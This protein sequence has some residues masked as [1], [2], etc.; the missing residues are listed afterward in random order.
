MTSPLREVTTLFL[1]L[2]L[3][4]FGGPAAH[5]ALMHE[6]VV[7]RRRWVDDA[8]FLD[9]VGLA[10]LVPGP[11]STELAIHLGRERAGWRGFAAA[12][13]AFIAPAMLMVLG[14]A[15]LY[16][17]YGALPQ[18]ASLLE[19]VKAVMIA[20][21]AQALWT[22]VPKAV[23]G[24][25]TGVLGAAALALALAGVHEIALLFGAGLLA[26]GIRM[27]RGGP[28]PVAIAVPVAALRDSTPGAVTAAAAAATAAIAVPFSLPLL[29][30]SFLKIGAVM[31]G[32][33]YVLL[34]FLRA[35]F[36]TRFGWLT[37]QQVLDAVAIGQITPGPL[38]TAA[39][40]IGHQL[41]GVPGAL[42]ATLGIFLPS[43]VF[44]ALTGPLLGGRERSPLLGAFLDGVN[45]AAL[46]LMAAV[47]WQ[48]G[49]SVLVDV[50]VVLV[51]VVSLVLLVRTSLPSLWLIAGG[52]AFGLARAF[53]G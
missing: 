49:R 5:L 17:R 1:R 48:L 35:E 44:V 21:I 38:F 19:G 15:W 2:G 3:T 4:A 42:L 6:Q 13:V 52:A 14:L 39:T 9:L 18:A 51:T 10:N 36:V 31:Y 22:L 50:P 11:N 28:G 46:G 53:I 29:F 27:A 41:G 33:G 45:V 12:G 16:G 37:E 43:F 23:K 47:T 34:A 24:P 25:L 7:R 30:L 8:R 32:S 40:F 20:I 26:L